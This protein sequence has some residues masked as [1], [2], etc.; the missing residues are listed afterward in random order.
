MSVPEGVLP[1]WQPT[2][3]DYLFLALSFANTSSDSLG[4][5]ECCRRPEAVDPP[6]T[7][8]QGSGCGGG[9]S[10]GWGAFVVVIPCGRVRDY[11]AWRK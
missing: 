4:R 8:R 9:L 3:L 7:M 5:P 6:A 11:G 10:A 1:G 2:Y